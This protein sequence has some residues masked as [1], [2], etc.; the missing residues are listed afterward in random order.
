MST[1]KTRVSPDSSSLC[2]APRPY[3][4]GTTSMTWLPTVCSTR[5]SDHAATESSENDTGCPVVHVESNG[6]PVDH[7]KPVYCTVTSSPSATCAPDPLM[8]GCTTSS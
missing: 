7:A 4:G 2:A 1:T 3:D 5:P 6:S 8:R